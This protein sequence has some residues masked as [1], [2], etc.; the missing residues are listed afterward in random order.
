MGLDILGEPKS[1]NKHTHV[2]NVVI[3]QAGD[4]LIKITGH[5][6]NFALTV[7]Y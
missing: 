2:R 7:C 6:M 1:S 3:L 5:N 4:S